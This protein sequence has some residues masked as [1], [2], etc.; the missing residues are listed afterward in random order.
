MDLV[1][2]EVSLR[3]SGSKGLAVLLAPGVCRYWPLPFRCGP[4]VDVGSAFRITPLVRLAHWPI[5]LR[6]VALSANRVQFYE[7]TRDEIRELEV[8]PGTPTSLETFEWGPDVGRPVR[9]QTAAGTRGTTQLVHGQA[10]TNEEA[11]TRL[12]AYVQAV[13]HV[14]GQ[15]T[16]NASLPLILL[17][18]KSYIPS[19]VTHTCH[20]TSSSQESMP[21]PPTFQP[22][23]CTSR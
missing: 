22:P 15:A 13:A 10:S 8:P 11:Q 20:G 1:R 18:S 4:T 17:L 2:D 3:E 19:F 7:C 23:R 5:Q 9:F 12:H 21:A 16:S 14:I 6:I